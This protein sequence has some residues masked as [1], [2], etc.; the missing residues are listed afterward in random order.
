M[1]PAIQPCQRTSMAV[2]HRVG[3]GQSGPTASPY[4]LL[5]LQRL[6]S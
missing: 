4:L 6:W 5:I 2:V 3:R 1:V